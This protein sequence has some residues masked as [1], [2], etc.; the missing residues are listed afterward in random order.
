[1]D[2]HVCI[3]WEKRGAYGVLVGKCEGKKIFG[4]MYASVG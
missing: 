3:L 4:I 1:M 2:G